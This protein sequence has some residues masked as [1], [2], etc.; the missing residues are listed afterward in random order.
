MLSGGGFCF[1]YFSFSICVVVCFRVG[2]V[3]SMWEMCRRCCVC[4]CCV[5][6]CKC[7]SL[8]LC[9]ASGVCLCP[10]EFPHVFVLTSP[11]VVWSRQSNYC[12]LCGV[13]RLF[14][15][16]VPLPSLIPAG[17]ACEQ[18]Y[19]TKLVVKSLFRRRRSQGCARFHV[20]VH[21]LGIGA[22]DYDTCLSFFRQQ[23]KHEA[24]NSRII[25]MS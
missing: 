10:P 14:S 16:Y 23:C 12:L 11:R 5:G 13:V 20:A 19:V 15:V 1:W 4:C 9:C 25:S 8:T 17:E 18:S 6:H 3:V 21:G 2:L 22:Q 24:S 7:S